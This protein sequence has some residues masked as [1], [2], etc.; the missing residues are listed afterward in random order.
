[1]KTVDSLYLN[2]MTDY[3]LPFVIEIAYAISA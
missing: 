2:R 1:M 3:I